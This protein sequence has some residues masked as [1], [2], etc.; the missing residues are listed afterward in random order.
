MPGTSVTITG[1]NFNASLVYNRLKQNEKPAQLQSVTGTTQLTATVPPYATSGPWTL[2]TP[3][4]IGFSASD[5]FVPPTP[6]GV[7]DVEY[8]ARL[9]PGT[10]HPVTISTA[11][12]IALLTFGATAGERISVHLS[13]GPIGVFR[14]FDPN[15]AEVV[16][17]AMTLSTVFIDT[18]ALNIT[19]TYTAMVDPSNANTRRIG[20]D[21]RGWLRCFGEHHNTR[22]EHAPDVLGNDRA[23]GQC[24]G[25]GYIGLLRVRLVFEGAK[26]RRH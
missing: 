3:F 22:T 21:C 12:K 17:S 13:V 16:S 5:F 18:T 2:M 10:P 23:A 26:G 1:T 6:Y 20:T 11:T 8:T 19:G 24:E 14:I 25:N 9:T 7:S 4:G 15:G